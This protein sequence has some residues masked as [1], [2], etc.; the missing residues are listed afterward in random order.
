G[1]RGGGGDRG[2]G[3]RRPQADR[4]RA[5]RLEVAAADAQWRFAGL[6]AEAASAGVDD[7]RPRVGAARG[8]AVA[9]QEGRQRAGK[10]GERRTRK[11]RREE[12]ES[13]GVASVRAM[14]PASRALALRIE[15]TS[16][17]ACRTT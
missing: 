11:D 2:P 6:R 3:G 9:E 8:V 4:L 16:A 15:L 10:V 13:H 7:A 5:R 1:D 17:H 14:P 12:K